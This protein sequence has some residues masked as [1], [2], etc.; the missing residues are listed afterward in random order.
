MGGITQIE[1]DSNRSVPGVAEHV[2][3]PGEQVPQRRA[4]EAG[5]VNTVEVKLSDWVAEVEL[6]C[7]IIVLGDV[8]SP[9][10]SDI[11]LHAIH[12]VLQV[13]TKMLA[14]RYPRKIITTK[15][16]AWKISLLLQEG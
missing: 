8:L 15:L 11:M 4:S 10:Y 9:L 14:R 13:V 12:F 7:Q 1:H 5:V 6:L 3:L 16:H 2:R